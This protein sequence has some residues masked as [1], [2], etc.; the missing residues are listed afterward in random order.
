M[1]RSLGRG[2]LRPRNLGAALR[3]GFLLA[4]LATGIAGCSPADGERQAAQRSPASDAEWAWLQQTQRTLDERRAKL[5]S[6]TAADPQF[7]RETEIL[8]GAFNR[9]LIDFLNADPPVQGE[10]LTDRQ[11]A[12][13]RMKSDEDILLA[14]Q[15]IERGG[16]YQR[17]IDIYKEA[18]IVDP[19]YSRLR[20]ELARAQ[21]RR[22]MTRQTFEQV[23]EGMDREEVRRLLGQ[24]NLHNV[25]AYPDR[26]V[27]GWFYPKDAS[28]AAAAVWFHKE[29]NR[30][31]VYL[32]DFDALQP[33]PETGPAGPPQARSPQR[34]T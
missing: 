12:A 7:A 15:F 8:A 16:D 17:A 26:D 27:I 18:L 19:A 31:T 32:F 33:R 2:R 4:M 20:E 3:A 9:R 24:P 13:I 30:Y 5:A 11:K 28:G 25:R 21:A 1:K 14:R 22:Y 6:G 34:S 29:G 23:K 10:P